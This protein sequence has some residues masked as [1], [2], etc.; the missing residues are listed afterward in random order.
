MIAP[1]FFLAKWNSSGI[2][3]SPHSRENLRFHTDFV[4]R[5]TGALVK[6]RPLSD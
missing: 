4:V 6:S 5:I 2:G 3:N 1:Q